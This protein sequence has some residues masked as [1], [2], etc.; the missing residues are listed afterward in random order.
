MR[1]RGVQSRRYGE[2][3]A[4]ACAARG[5]E[6]SGSVSERKHEHHGHGI[7]D[8]EHIPHSPGPYWRRAHRDW[9]VWVALF[10]C[11]LAVLIYVVTDD[12]AI[13]F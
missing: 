9:R 7:P 12:L 13:R 4:P 8:G 3:F 1:P 2:G 6:E 11:L 10:F 5:L